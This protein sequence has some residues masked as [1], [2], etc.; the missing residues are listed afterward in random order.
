MSDATYRL[1]KPRA[2]EMSA[3][4][5]MGMPANE[6]AEALLTKCQNGQRD[7]MNKT[8]ERLTLWQKV[9][10]MLG[11]K[12]QVER[13]MEAGEMADENTTTEAPAPQDGTPA[14]APEAPQPELAEAAK[15]IQELEAA[16]KA[17]T[18][19]LEKGG[20]R[21]SF[22]DKLPKAMHS[23][24]DKMSEEEQD[25]MMERFGKA[26]EGEPDDGVSKAMGDL[27]QKQ[28]DTEALLEKMKTDA[29]VTKTK[30]ELAGISKAIPDLDR[31]S[32]AVVTLRKASPEDVKVILEA[33][34][35][36]IAQS[37]TSDLYKA[38]GA[39][40]EGGSDGPLG[41]LESTAKAIQKSEGI[42]YAQAYAK[43]L[44]QNPD[45]YKQYRSELG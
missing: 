20:A 41:K 36:A 1:H 25:A 34:K 18:D 22:R 30:E 5:G 35:A 31:Y 40:S 38:A 9:G 32:R 16:N 17:L 8:D 15:R 26:A 45:L 14:A 37:D 29:E 19:K 23:A 42:S 44:E 39:R 33:H 21:S 13:T 10:I 3:T 4:V 43:A 7:I 11:L 27:L 12:K 28:R 24:Y 6:H 2:D